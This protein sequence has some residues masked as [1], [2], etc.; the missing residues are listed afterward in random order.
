MRLKAL[1]LAAAMTIG[2]VSTAFAGTWKQGISRPGEYWYDYG[3]GTY[4]AN[5]WVWIDGNHDG[6]AECYYFD[7]G[8]WMI[9]SQQAPD[10][11][12]TND[13]G[14]WTLRGVVQ[15]RAVT[16]GAVIPCN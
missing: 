4:A 12:V 3:N 16:P 10:G 6:V 11:Y 9:H 14:A 13:T 1:V 7:N 15:Q 5:Q 8:G 2:M